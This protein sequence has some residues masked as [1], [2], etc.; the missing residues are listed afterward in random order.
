MGQA[1]K[2]I[3]LIKVIEILKKKKI[4]KIENIFLIK[5]KWSKKWLFVW[6]RAR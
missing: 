2:G 6:R 4:T 3:R 5:K 1:R